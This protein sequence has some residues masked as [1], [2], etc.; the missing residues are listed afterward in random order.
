MKEDLL[1]LLKLELWRLMA[2][3]EI[4]S[5]TFSGLVGAYLDLAIAYLLLCGSTFA[6]FASKFLSIFGLCLPCPC[7]GFFGNP[8]GDNCFHKFLVHYPSDHV[9]SVQLCVKSKFPFDSVWGNDGSTSH[10]NWKLLKEINSDDG[11]EAPPPELEGQASCSSHW[12]LM[13]SP[14]TV[15]EEDSISR[16]G[17]SRRLILTNTPGKSDFTGKRV[18]N[19]RPKTGIRRRRRNAIDHGKFSSVSSH[20]PPRLDAPNGIRSPS[21][22]SR[23]GEAFGEETLFPDSSGRECGFQGKYTFCFLD[24]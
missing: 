18:S 1:D 19:Q 11:D 9:S 12:G 10:P 2:C 20:D 14:S 23:T 6:F 15:G 17:S 3:Q 13:R 4:H 21:S 7:N 8:N 22:V 5:W 16:N 24:F